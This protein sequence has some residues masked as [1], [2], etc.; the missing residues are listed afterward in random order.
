MY[1]AD[2]EGRGWLFYIQ[3]MIDFSEKVLSYT[4]GMDQEAFIA[5][6]RTYDATLRNLEPIGEA[7]THI[8]SEVRKAHPQVQWRNMIGTRNRVA[9]GYL[10][11]DD[12]VVWDIIRADIPNLL[13]ALRDLL[14]STSEEPT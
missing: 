2:H 6:E 3:E 9:H 7:A 1:E 4:G 11:I 5:D 10:G 8:P 13:P 14:D 12:D